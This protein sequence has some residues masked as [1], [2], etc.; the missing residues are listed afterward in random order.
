MSL[1]GEQKTLH[2]DHIEDDTG[3]Y[4]TKT[5]TLTVRIYP[6]EADPD[7]LVARR[8]FEEELINTV[9]HAGDGRLRVD[10]LTD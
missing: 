8:K 3:S 6:T 4:E 2:R 5:Y 1:L 7:A 10:T 9:I